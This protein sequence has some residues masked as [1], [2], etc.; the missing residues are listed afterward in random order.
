M[1]GSTGGICAE[2]GRE[3]CESL[4]NDNATPQDS[5]PN[6]GRGHGADDADSHRPGHKR[7]SRKVV[8]QEKKDRR[9][10]DADKATV[11]DLESDEGPEGECHVRPSR[12]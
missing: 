1:N 6:E 2:V 3:S 5:G 11:G 10:Q 4:A 8:R 9:G 12:R 7:A